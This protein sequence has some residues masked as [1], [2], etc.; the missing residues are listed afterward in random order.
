MKAA[1]KATTLGIRMCSTELLLL[2]NQ[3]GSTCYPMTLFKRDS[4]ADIFIGILNF[5]F[6]Q[7]IS[8]NSSKT[9]DYKGF[10]FA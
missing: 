9:T 1:L 7:A 6:G 8:Q 4:T 5:V 3:K 10:L 2:K